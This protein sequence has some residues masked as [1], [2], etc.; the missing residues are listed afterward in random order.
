MKI[1]IKDDLTDLHSFKCKVKIKDKKHIAAI[2]AVSQF[3][4][5]KEVSGKIGWM[6]SFQRYGMAFLLPNLAILSI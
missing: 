6:D 2:I 5:R 3:V 4:K 1:L